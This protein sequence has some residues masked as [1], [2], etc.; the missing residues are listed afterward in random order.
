MSVK[1]DW[2]LAATLRC[3]VVWLTAV[4]LLGSASVE[5]LAEEHAFPPPPRKIDDISALL[6]KAEIADKGEYKRL[7]AKVGRD[8]PEGASKADLAKFYNARGAAA[9]DLGNTTQALEDL[10]EAARIV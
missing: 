8:P 5:L 3:L 1:L 7:L 6:D 9:A 4:L 2:R 10:R